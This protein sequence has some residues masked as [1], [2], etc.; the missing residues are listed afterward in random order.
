MNKWITKYINFAGWLITG[1]LSFSL[2]AGVNPLHIV[3][4]IEHQSG[5]LTYTLTSPH[6]HAND[7]NTVTVMIKAL[8][9]DSF[10]VFYQPIGVRQ[11]SSFALAQP[12]QPSSVATKIDLNNTVISPDWVQLTTQTS[13][14]T[15]NL[16]T[17]QL[18]F[19]QVNDHGKAVPV[20]EEEIGFFLT[21]TLRG[22]R[23]KLDDDEQLL[24]GGQRVLGMNRRGHRMPLYNR[25]H[26]GYTTDSNQ[27][28]YSIPA[29][30]SDQDYAIL[31][32]NSASGFL[33]IGHTRANVLQFEAVAGRTSYIV[34]LGD[35]IADVTQELTTVTGKQ[36]LPP[37][38]ALGNFASRFGY[39]TQQETIDTVNLFKSQDIPLDAVVLDL[40]WFGKDI[41]GHMGNLTWDL[42]AFPS[43]ENMISEFKAQGVNTIVI[44]EPFI[45]SSSKQW[46]SAVTANALAKDV[47]GTPR[48]FD[49]YF[50]NTGLVD[51]FDMDGQA[52]FNEF[53]TTLFKQGVTGWW[54]DLGEPEVHPGDS[55]HQFAGMTVTGDEIHNA[56]GHQWAKMVYQHQKK[57]DPT[58]RPFVMMRSGFL[59]SQ[60]YGLIPWT[61]DVSRSWGGLKPQVELALQMSVMGLAYIHSDI[62]GFAGGDTFD[63]ELY[64]R[65]IQ[66]GAF[67]PVFR[68]H[69]QENIPP[70]PVFHS[71]DV[72][73]LAR[74]YIKLRYA[75]TPYNYTLAMEN[76]LTGL[77]LMRPISYLDEQQFTQK[78][79]YLWGHSIL[80][81]PVVDAGV[82]EVE[83]DVPKGVWFDFF[84]DKKIEGDDLVIIDAPL[85]KLP[86][87]IKAGSFIPMVAPTDHLKAYSTAYLDMH[88][89]YDPSVPKSHYRLLE[90]DGQDPNSLA[91]GRY[92]SIDFTS[93]TTIDSPNN[94][95]LLAIDAQTQGT[96]AGAPH[97]RVINYIIH[98]VSQM[99]AE[100]AINGK[101][102][103][104]L[105][106]KVTFDQ[107]TQQLSI[108][109]TLEQGIG[110]N[111]TLKM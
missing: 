70:E 69:A 26:Y 83:I 18:A 110:L 7:N 74:Q 76:A 35:D 2:H 98:N 86:L 101:T 50:G 93:V 4:D 31:F 68:P 94:Q 12:N 100:I 20:V 106:I 66:F 9:N 72:K 13:A 103:E 8:T 82:T 25:A 62:G 15:V 41:K 78:D 58:I 19:G 84:S 88:F 79:S 30:I 85:E 71:E 46:D 64:K 33:D 6:L 49:F 45:L 37:R 11:I 99:P 80:V 60:R 28:Y 104:A 56:Y 63:A 17:G 91:S 65:W 40:Y 42:N 29:V 109:L 23:F 21:N 90:D 38:W 102:F 53:Y 77:P 14:V 55:L 51:V 97:S 107:V 57:M 95:T 36:P 34:V 32:D 75:L 22:F 24:G 96:Y 73:D 61:G 39:R 1:W 16:K 54:G 67:S 44:T 111:M 105:G 48:R 108:P 92:Q 87:L 27:M 5:T 47:D 52:W 59:G 10:E 43:P 89:Y 3:S 81:H